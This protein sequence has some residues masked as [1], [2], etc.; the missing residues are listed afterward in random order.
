MLHTHSVPTALI[1]VQGSFT[2]P[3]NIEPGVCLPARCQSSLDKRT[4]FIFCLRFNN[5]ANYTIWSWSTSRTV[6]M[7][8]MFTPVTMFHYE[9]QAMESWKSV[10]T[11]IMMLGKIIWMY[12]FE[13][14]QVY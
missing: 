11:I 12:L 5:T 14:G 6:F 2:W 7:T 8:I 13:V 10:R 4:I 3:L 1:L 9:G